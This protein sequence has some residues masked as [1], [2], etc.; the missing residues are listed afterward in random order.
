M[1]YKRVYRTEVIDLLLQNEFIDLSKLKLASDGKRILFDEVEVKVKRECCRFGSHYHV[2]VSVWEF[3]DAL[4]CLA[5]LNTP[6]EVENDELK[7]ELS[8]WLSSQESKQFKMKD[9]VAWIQNK[10]NLTRKQLEISISKT[11]KDLGWRSKHTKSGNVW[12]PDFE[13]SQS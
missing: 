11:L 4:Y 9:I 3:K 10:E 8:D 13:F 12:V 1:R 7:K 2:E 5:E 6:E